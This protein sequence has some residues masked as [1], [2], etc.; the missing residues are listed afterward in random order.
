MLQKVGFATQTSNLSRERV[1]RRELYDVLATSCMKCW[2]GRVLVPFCLCFLIW[3]WADVDCHPWSS[4]GAFDKKLQFP[5]QWIKE[6]D[7][8]LGPSFFI[9]LA[10]RSRLSS[11][12]LSSG[13]LSPGYTFIPVL[14]MALHWKRSNSQCPLGQRMHFGG[15]WQ[16]RQA[17]RSI[18]GLRNMSGNSLRHGT[19]HI[20]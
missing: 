10:S 5:M 14:H 12:L 7:E 20:G 11:R 1:S 13:L 16:G 3:L 9:G 18:G 2:H 19:N 8:Y 4:Y 17:F 6:A 15:L